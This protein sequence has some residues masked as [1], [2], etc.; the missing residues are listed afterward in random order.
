MD[1]LYGINTCYE[2][3]KIQ[4]FLHTNATK[5]LMIT[6]H[7]SATTFLY[8]GQSDLLHEI[9]KLITIKYDN[10]ECDVVSP[11]KVLNKSQDLISAICDRPS[12]KIFHC[13]CQEDFESIK[14]MMRNQ[15][16]FDLSRLMDSVKAT[17][18]PSS[19]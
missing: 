2:T 18:T 1:G 12:Q 19:E 8:V 14:S 4:Q 16:S 5:Y 3:E 6:Q 11:Y 10:E 9:I 17:I 7:N 13:K 15:S